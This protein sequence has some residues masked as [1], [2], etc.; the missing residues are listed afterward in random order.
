[1]SGGRPHPASHGSTG[2]DSVD[3]SRSLPSFYNGH[4]GYGGGGH[5]YANR[6]TSFSSQHSAGRDGGVASLRSG[7]IRSVGGS[8][9]GGGGPNFPTPTS[10]NFPSP[11][12][13]TRTTA[14]SGGG[15]GSG[16]IVR[17]ARRPVR[18]YPALLSRVA[19]A[20]RSGLTLTERVKDG[21]AYKD[22]FDGREAVDLLCALLDTDNRNLALLLGRALDFQKFFHDVTYDHRLRD[23]TNEL[24]QFKGKVI[25]PNAPF[26]AALGGSAP[27]V[28]GTPDGSHGEDGSSS[29]TDSLAASS[30]TFGVPSRS[31]SVF[32]SAGER[33]SISSLP[34]T[35]QHDPSASLPTSPGSVNH[36][37]A[38]QQQLAAASAIQPQDG[39]DLPSGV[40]TL[41]SACYSPTCSATSLCYSI[42]CPLRIEQ[43]KK[44][45][46]KPQPGL[47]KV[48]SAASLKD[49]D[50]EQADGGPGLWANGVSQAVLDSVGD[51]E[52][53]R[54]EAINE[55]IFTERDFVK[56]MEYLR[57]VRSFRRASGPF[58]LSS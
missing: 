34:T 15:G 20:F 33:S 11:S 1:M 53:K 25:V 55:L 32:T 57:D 8:G 48:A 46:M 24:Y 23:S 4:G 6:S 19:D 36:P 28:G 10:Y 21:L 35:V 18:I 13:S 22:A 14:T 41:L 7:S 47:R 31:P 56:D 51:E 2:R 49:D 5:G 26:A 54:Q 44:L 12:G 45:N 38:A 30:L 43:A 52:R 50:E 9:S 37:S 58:K 3:S 39:D 27:A 16:S 40:F 29:I 42:S 17:A